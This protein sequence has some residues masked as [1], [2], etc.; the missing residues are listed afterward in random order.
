[1]VWSIKWSITAENQ[2]KKIDKK[3]AQKIVT[4]LD[5]I[6]DEP[7]VYTKKLASKASAHATTE[8]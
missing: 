1:M 2:L 4:K 7:Y 3:N 6:V 5:K 8:E